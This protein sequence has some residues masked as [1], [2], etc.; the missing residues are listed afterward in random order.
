MIILQLINRINPLEKREKILRKLI[1]L[2]IGKEF[3]SIRFHNFY[4]K[5]DGRNVINLHTRLILEICGE[6][7]YSTVPS[8]AEK[9]KSMILFPFHF[10]LLVSANPKEYGHRLTLYSRKGMGDKFSEQIISENYLEAYTKIINSFL[11][12]NK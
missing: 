10:T 9:I 2:F 11:D 1:E 12:W 8:H 7:S 5:K 6:Y 3:D 4:N